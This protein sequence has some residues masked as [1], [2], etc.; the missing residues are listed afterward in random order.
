MSST[1]CINTWDDV[2][3]EF[4][5]RQAVRSQQVKLA[6]K[7]TGVI[8]TAPA[9]Q[10]EMAQRPVTAVKTAPAP[11][12]TTET[13][14]NPAETARLNRLIHARRTKTLPIRRSFLDR[15]AESWTEAAQTARAAQRKPKPKGLG[16]FKRTIAMMVCTLVAVYAG[17][18]VASAVQVAAAIQ[19][20][21]A[22][23]LAQH[24]DWASLR[25][26]LAAAL[27]AEAQSNAS[28]PMP[29]FISGMAQ[30][31]AG[32]LASPAG[33]AVLLNERL[34]VPRG[35]SSAPAR[36]M[37]SHVRMVDAG[38][39]E[40]TLSSPDAPNRSAKL[41]LALAD[42]VRLRWEVRAIELPTRTQIRAR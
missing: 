4:D 37:L 19:R 24:V 31:M 39:W 23:A 8:E 38:L 11:R 40:V 20:G 30:D 3:A 32:R 36:E 6:A 42:A 28:Q 14:A 41:T 7:M 22:A 5:A 21:D 18:P 15:S 33:L 16:R 12:T 13:M 29:D 2:W 9:E 10:T 17:S 34:A 26:A 25:P 35:G 27:S 1:T